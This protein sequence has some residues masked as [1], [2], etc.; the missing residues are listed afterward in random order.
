MRECRGSWINDTVSL[1]RRLSATA[2]QPH[3]PDLFLRRKIPSPGVDPVA[4]DTSGTRYDG[5]IVEQTASIN[6][7]LLGDFWRYSVP[8][9]LGALRGDR[10]LE[11]CYIWWVL[12]PSENGELFP[13]IWWFFCEIVWQGEEKGGN[14]GQ[15]GAGLE[16][17]LWG[18]F[19]LSI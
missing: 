5:P 1:R 6:V 17:C 19:P 7:F 2:C 12:F 15:N 18:T 9:G 16:T 14:G 10:A 3:H 8:V 11:H 4:C 13:E